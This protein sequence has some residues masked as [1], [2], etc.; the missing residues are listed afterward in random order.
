MGAT[1]F[2]GMLVTLSGWPAHE[3]TFDHLR[4]VRARKVAATYLRAKAPDKIIVAGG[5]A[6]EDLSIPALGYVDAPLRV[7]APRSD[8]RSLARASYYYEISSQPQRP[9]EKE[10]WQRLKRCNLRTSI[11]MAGAWR[12]PFTKGSVLLYYLDSPGVS[13]P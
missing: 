11:A 5:K 12:A 10:T 8:C 4:Y 6:A 3:S 13:T 7:V 2:N 1:A 9:E